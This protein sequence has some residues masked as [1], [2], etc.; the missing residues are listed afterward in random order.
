MVHR[1]RLLEG[2]ESYI[3]PTNIIR[4]N[5][6]QGA[7]YDFV[8]KYDAKLNRT[9]MMEDRGMSTVA[10]ILGRCRARCTLG[11]C[12]LSTHQYST[13]RYFRVLH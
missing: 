2:Y 10:S 4:M 3:V 1:N 8:H 5:H 13:H 7:R 9:I 11:C 12:Y 6:Y